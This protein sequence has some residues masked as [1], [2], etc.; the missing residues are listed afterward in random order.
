MFRKN[1]VGV[2]MVPRG[3]PALNELKEVECDYR[4]S[5]VERVSWKSRYI[6]LKKCR[7]KEG[8]AGYQHATLYEEPLKYQKQYLA[9]RLEIPRTY[10]NCE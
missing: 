1:G 10:S 4:Y 7:S 3:K 8:C 9:I 5:S 2:R 6:I